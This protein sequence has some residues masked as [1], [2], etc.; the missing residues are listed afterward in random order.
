M[1]TY[2]SVVSDILTT[3]NTEF[4][5]AHPGVLVEQ[6]NADIA[7]KESVTEWVRIVVREGGTNQITLSPP[8][9]R[10]W[11]TDSVVIVQLFSRTGKGA[12]VVRG[13]ASTV[14]DIFRGRKI[15]AATFRGVRTNYQNPGPVWFQ[16]NLI[17]DFFNR[18]TK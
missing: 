16:Q 5:A 17:A 6:D 11:Q 7:D 4:T 9:S 12:G 15:G 18:D 14:R 3:F 13:M 1:S 8:G 2:E 10:E